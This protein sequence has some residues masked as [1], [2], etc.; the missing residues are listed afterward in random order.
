M[1]SG[2]LGRWLQRLE[3]LHP[4]EIE[5]GLDRVSAVAGRLGLLAPSA[6]IVT[7]AGTNG[8]GSTVAVLE[9][10][11]S[12]RGRRVGCYT[13][14]HFLRFNERIRV[15]G[16]EVAD[17][18]I[19]AAFE[20]VEE[21]RQGVSLTYFEYTTLAALWLFAA[22][23]CDVL[24]LE[25]GV[26]GRLD[27]VN[28]VDPAV[29]VITSID[30]DH[31][32]WL[33]ESRGEIAL[34]K[35]GI[36]RPGRPVV[37]ADPDPPPELVDCL[38]A[39]GAA[40]VL[41]LGREF[42]AGSPGG[43]SWSAELR[44]PGGGMRVVARLERG[45]LLRANIAAALQAALLLGLSFSDDEA[46]A[47]ARAAAPRGRRQHGRIAGR[48]CILDVAHNPASVKKLREYLGSIDCFGK[49]IA[50][51]S[52]MADK[53]LQGMLDPVSGDFD[54]WFLADQP[55]NPRAATAERLA[56]LLRERGASQI[57]LSDNLQEACRRA[58]GAMGAADQLVVFGSF[59]TVAA[60]L[61]LLEGEAGQ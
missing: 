16:R 9:A 14:P 48:E 61:P 19:V 31:Q 47:A 53:D 40:P 1:S 38:A 10:L 35:A 13:S 56:G 39:T 20:R 6:A 4:S 52:A 2:S 57:S 34:E 5:L 42:R 55:G 15:D 23:G 8:K 28:I 29:A 60:V 58:V 7:V 37:V 21:G 30:L 12:A 49:R 43:G 46:R 50:I 33:G 32:A 51:F 17:H 59:H 3:S 41:Y 24:V 54:A 25:V 27:A 45:P 26:G 36:A 44:D 11:L 22:H 18:E